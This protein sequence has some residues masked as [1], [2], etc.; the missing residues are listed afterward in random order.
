MLQVTTF[1]KNQSLKASRTQNIE[2]GPNWNLTN[3]IE[4]LRAPTLQTPN[5]SSSDCNF[6][7]IAVLKCKINK[8]RTDASKYLKENWKIVLLTKNTSFNY[9]EARLIN[10]ALFPHLQTAMIIETVGNVLTAW[11]I[12][13]SHL[14]LCFIVWLY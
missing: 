7:V 5:S 9:L 12:G 3:E 13:A 1:Y 8:K 10:D 6:V 2:N 4:D 11:R 14:Q